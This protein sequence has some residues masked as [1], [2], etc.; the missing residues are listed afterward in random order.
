VG[1]EEENSACHPT[2]T[3]RGFAKGEAL[4]LLCTNFSKALFEEEINDFNKRLTKKGYPIN[5]VENVLFEV[6]HEGRKLSLARKTKKNLNEQFT[7]C[8][9]QFKTNTHQ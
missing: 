2:S 6:K 8:S 7:S 1:E 5:F 4:S 3:K 9:A